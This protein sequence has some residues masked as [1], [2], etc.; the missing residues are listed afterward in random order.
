MSIDVEHGKGTVD[1]GEACELEGRCS[2]CRLSI[3]SEIEGEWDGVIPGD[4]AEEAA[5][6][7]KLV[8]D[9]NGGVEIGEDV[10]GTR[11]AGEEMTGHGIDLR[12][13][14]VWLDGRMDDK[15]SGGLSFETRL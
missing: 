1:A 6:A 11:G 13:W 10:A 8:D 15:W 9:S 7:S 14:W 5:T 4:D 3:D 12:N 2:W